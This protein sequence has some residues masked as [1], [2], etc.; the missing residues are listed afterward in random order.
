MKPIRI[1]A[2]SILLLTTTTAPGLAVS[3]KPTLPPDFAGANRPPA[4]KPAVVVKGAATPTPP[5]GTGGPKPLVVVK[6][7]RGIPGRLPST[8][9]PVPNFTAMPGKP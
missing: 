2:A 1:V 3:P 7:D 8:P 6:Q 5:R 4:Q 9:P